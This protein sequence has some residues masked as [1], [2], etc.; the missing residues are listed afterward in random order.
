M[1]PVRKD[2]SA[3]NQNLHAYYEKA[4]TAT[5][6][7]RQLN[8]RQRL[9]PTPVMKHHRYLEEVEISRGVHA[10]VV[11]AVDG[12]TRDVIAIKT[13]YDKILNETIK[14]EVQILKRLNHV[15]VPSIL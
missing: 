3:Y 15:R 6:L 14:D 7:L 8:I 13:Y 12:S 1:I 5:P 4:V 2:P 11:S 9:K 10:R